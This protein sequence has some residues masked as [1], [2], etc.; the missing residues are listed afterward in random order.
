MASHDTN[1]VTTP[2]KSKPAI[3]YG[4][5]IKSKKRRVDRSPV[6]HLLLRR[7]APGEPNVRPRFVA[8]ARRWPTAY[9]HQNI[10]RGE[11]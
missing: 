1:P 3:A 9:H 8:L 6:E 10:P 2:K 7:Y 11:A 4:I 5:D